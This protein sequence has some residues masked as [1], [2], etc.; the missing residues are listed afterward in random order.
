MKNSSRCF[1]GKGIWLWIMGRVSGGILLPF[2]ARQLSSAGIE[3]LDIFTAETSI[4][5]NLLL[6]ELIKRNFISPS[7]LGEIMFELWEKMYAFFIFSIFS[8]QESWYK[9]LTQSIFVN[10]SDNSAELPLETLMWEIV[11]WTKNEFEFET[12]HTSLQSLTFSAYE[13][14]TTGKQ[15]QNLMGELLFQSKSSRLIPWYRKF[16]KYVWINYF[17][18]LGRINAFS[19]FR[20]LQSRTILLHGT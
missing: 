7:F 17:R 12:K 19:T 16:S 5:W 6:G 4:S 1:G 3:M 14:F 15:R 9:K 11:A 2:S 18:F 13:T 8:L 20:Q 10:S